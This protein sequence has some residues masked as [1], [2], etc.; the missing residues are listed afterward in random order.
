[1]FH[2]CTIFAFSS[3]S[4]IAHILCRRTCMRLWC[5]AMLQS[6]TWLTHFFN[7]GVGLYV[8]LFFSC[9]NKCIQ[10]ELQVALGVV[11]GQKGGVCECLCLF[12]FFLSNWVLFPVFL[13]Y[14]WLENT[15]IP[16]LFCCWWNEWFQ[17]RNYFE[18]GFASNSHYSA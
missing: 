7:C 16:L 11:V 5:L 4:N 3:S 15:M 1:M 14:W 2:I 17:F 6:H 8:P 10:D 9:L 12:F 18:K 13:Y